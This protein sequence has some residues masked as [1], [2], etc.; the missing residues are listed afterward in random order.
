MAA[1]LPILK[2]M[3]EAMSIVTF[4]QFIEEEAIQACQLGAYMAFRQKRYKAA[5]RA[6][7]V[8]RSQ[9]LY[10][11]KA[12]NDIVGTLAPYSYLAFKDFITATETTLDVYDDLLMGAAMEARGS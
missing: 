6:M 8:T 5:A 9:L 3:A 11:L 2:G 4:I 12:T 7:Q 10:H 1:L